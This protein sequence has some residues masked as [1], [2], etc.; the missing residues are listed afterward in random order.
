MCVCRC[1]TIA[2]LCHASHR[3][4]LYVNTHA[5]T[6]NV[7][8]IPCSSI[9]CQF[10]L[11]E[12]LVLQLRLVPGVVQHGLVGQGTHL[13]AHCDVLEEAG[14]AKGQ[15]LIMKCC[16]GPTASHKVLQADIYQPLGNAHY[17]DANHVNYYVTCLCC[18]SC[19]VL[20]HTT[21]L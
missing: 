1:P 4:V 8:Q 12:Q 10:E 16:I 2:L 18:V 20:L 19:P 17:A 15:L 11:G 5:V 9:E 7:H 6:T 3:H 14:H 13:V 21:L